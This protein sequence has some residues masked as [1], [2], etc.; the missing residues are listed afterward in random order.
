MKASQCNSLTTTASGT[1][2]TP[3]SERDGSGGDCDPYHSQDRLRMPASPKMP[4][5]N[6]IL[7][8]ILRE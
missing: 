3:G 5:G 8:C 1:I 6:E 4:G 7:F 2:F